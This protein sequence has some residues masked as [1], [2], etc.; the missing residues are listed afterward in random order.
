MAPL[1]RQP[2]PAGRNTERFRQRAVGQK[3]DHHHPAYAYVDCFISLTRPR[4]DY[5]ELCEKAEVALRLAE[6]HF[7][8][9]KRRSIPFIGIFGDRCWPYCLA[10]QACSHCS[11]DKL[12][13][14][15][16]SSSL[17]VASLARSVYIFI[18]SIYRALWWLAGVER[19]QTRSNAAPTIFSC[20]NRH[21]L[22]LFHVSTATFL[23]KAP[24]PLQF[25]SFTLALRALRPSADVCLLPI[26]SPKWRK[27]PLFCWASI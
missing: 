27:V 19:Q 1:N 6:S 7:Q 5:H 8:S 2:V 20:H 14:G 12:P 18:W 10:M 24:L 17:P 26:R 4:G 9:Q 25:C 22:D 21:N 13:F 15:S 11:L 3:A 23:S 16:S